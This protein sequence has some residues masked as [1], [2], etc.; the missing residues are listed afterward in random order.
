RSQELAER[1][2][3]F[4][5][6]LYSVFIGAL[7][8]SGALIAT[9]AAGTMHGRALGLLGVGLAVAITAAAL[10][11]VSAPAPL[12]RLIRRV[13]A[14]GPDRLSALAGTAAANLPVLRAALRRSAGELRRPH[15]ALI[16]AVAWWAFDIGVLFALL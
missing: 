13:A 7:A 4:L 14:G 16:G 15:P 1:L 5:L 9:G 10:A 2:L 6:L 3:A 12:E 11:V 8:V